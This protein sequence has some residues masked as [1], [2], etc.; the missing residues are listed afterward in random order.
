MYFYSQ[1][2]D[3]PEF[4]TKPLQQYDVIEGESATINISAKANPSAI[5]YSWSKASSS[6][7]LMPA[8]SND[9][10]VTAVLATGSIFNLSNV[11]R[12]QAGKY[13]LEASNE[14][15]SSFVTVVLNVLCK[16]FYSIL[17]RYKSLQFSITIFF[18]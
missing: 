3:K 10:A 13:K 18:C 4:E 6:T 16:Y 1:I 14:E 8:D 15:G 7:S 2:T 17:L 12:D 11:R 5:T 9:V